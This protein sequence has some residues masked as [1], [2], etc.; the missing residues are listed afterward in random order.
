VSSNA[1]ER[2]DVFWAPDSFRQNANPRLWLVLAAD[3][4]PYAGQEYICA[5][6]T[7]SNLPENHDGTDW[8]C[9]RDPSKTS[10][11]SP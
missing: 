5:T 7:T 3:S 2:G 4:L 9:G 8:F 11:C 10:Y 6:L 1:F